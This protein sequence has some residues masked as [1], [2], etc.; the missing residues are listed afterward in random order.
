[1]GSS[2]WIPVDYLENNFAIGLAGIPSSNFSGTW[3]VQHTFDDVGPDGKRPVQLNQAATVITVTGDLG[4]QYVGS[5]YQLNLGHGLSVG[6]SV[7][8]DSALPT[9]SGSFPVA[10]IVSQTSY[11]LTS[12]VNQAAADPGARAATLRAFPHATLVAQ[13]GR[14]DGNY[15]FPIRACRLTV[16]ALTAGY[17]DLILLQ[18]SGR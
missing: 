9:L 18:S 4:Q 3:S 6:D 14:L 12:L 10:S 1:M 16:T 15:A 8:L 7:V 5:G 11:T 2:L 17:V 13:T